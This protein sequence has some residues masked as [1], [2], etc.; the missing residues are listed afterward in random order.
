M[1]R[2][3][4][5]ATAL[6]A[7]LAAAPAAFAQ[8][9]PPVP[10]P[11]ALQQPLDDGCHRNP[12]G[13][14]DF[15]EPEW[16]FVDAHE[17]FNPDPARA[18]RVEATAYHPDLAGGD[19]PE[20][21][22]FY[23]FN[24]DVVP[25]PAYQY[26][27]AGDPEAQNGNYAPDL[28]G[29]LHIEWEAG[30]LP[31]WAWP[32]D[33][34]RMKVWGSWVW[35]CGHWGQGF[36]ADS[37][38]PGGSAQNDTD[39]FIPGTGQVPGL[40][41]EQ[42]EFH[43]WQFGVVTRNRPELSASGETQADVFGSS[44]GTPAYADSTCALKH[45]APT[46]LGYGP[47]WVACTQRPQSQ[48]QPV[49]DRDYSF[50]VPA[51]PK[52]SPDAQLRYR[53]VDHNPPGAGPHEVV[54][55]KDDGIEVTVPF[56]GFGDSG[57]DL[58]YGKTFYVG[59]QGDVQNYPAHL[60]LDLKQIRVFKSLDDPRPGDTSTQ[61]PPG[62][63]GVYIDVNGSW[64]YLNNV[65]PGLDH[66]NDNTTL[67]LGKTI[68]LHVPAGDP[69]RVYVDSRE[70]DL[71]KIAP[72]FNTT[73]AAEDND[74]PGSGEQDFASAETS[75]GD[76]AFNV[77]SDTDPSFRIDYSVRELSPAHT[78]PSPGHHCVDV[79]SPR[80][81][82]NAD[83]SRLARHH[84]VVKGRGRDRTCAG[85]GHRPRQVQASVA[86]LGTGDSK[87]NTCKFLRPNGRLG[88]AGPCDQPVFLDARHRKRWRLDMDAKL[89]R[90]RYLVTSRAIDH[91]GNVELP[92]HRRSRAHFQVG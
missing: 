63:Y 72:C 79:W 39:Y 14:L 77:P 89:G 75:V 50:F 9:P 58:G 18:R 60:Q 80:T 64:H 70:C 57:Q 45:P 34:D 19:L 52:P 61:A 69:V 37:G 10:A 81:R 21:H 43:P 7:S 74:G 66:V 15:T 85:Q 33:Q 62:E 67:D 29:R 25:D 59:W 16:V 87:T 55:P 78:G 92:I 48:H 13:F 76:H 17:S 12:A 86:K 8:D 51:P 90:G 20:S 84:V 88:D 35:D 4:L 46:G 47:D 82:I 6:V 44:R 5:I 68:D 11:D 73:E 65:A 27:V 32:T 1:N 42:T 26:L 56:K 28:G 53:V 40:R 23:D 54:Q 24:T 71:P 41:G 2:G 83:V 3:S 31:A 38:D 30:T 36:E 49:N 22:D 91:A